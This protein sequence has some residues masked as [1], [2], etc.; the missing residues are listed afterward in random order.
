MIQSILSTEL[1]QDAK[2]WQAECAAQMD[3]PKAHVLLVTTALTRFLERKYGLRLDVHVHD[4]RM[5]YANATEAKLLNIAETE[6]CLRRKVSLLSRNKV[7][8]DAESV[9]PLDVLPI[10][11][12]DELEAGKRP[13]ANLLSDRGLR[14]SRSNLSITQVKEEGLYHQCWA[15]RSVLSSESGARALV[16]EVFYDAM[17]RKID[18]LQSR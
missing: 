13:L 5:D 11:L 10:E 1:W 14:L 8:F 2:T 15:R 4:Q 6:R 18:Y 12:I 17:W 16:T 7:M 9:L 3:S